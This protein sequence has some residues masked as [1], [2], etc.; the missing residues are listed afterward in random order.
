MVATRTASG[1]VIPA[2]IS[3]FVMASRS[4]SGKTAS[5]IGAAARALLAPWSFTHDSPGISASGALLLA[6]FL[7]LAAAALS[8]ILSTW[9]YLVGKGLLMTVREMDMGTDDLP[10]DT[11]RQVAGS[12]VGSIG[13]W[14]GLL[15]LTVGIAVGVADALYRADR[16]GFR[17][18]VR[19]TCASTIW[20]VVWA[21][22]AVVANSVQQGEIRHP[23]AAVRAYAQLNQH[24]FRGSSALAPGPIER[25]PLVARGL[26]RPLA[27]VFPVIWSLALPPPNGRRRVSR[28]VLIG[29]AVVLSWIAW[30]GAW[31]LLPWTAL[32]TWAG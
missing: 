26:L 10:T 20:F 22:A 1:F 7:V 9:T 3:S 30:W 29:L 28:P 11:L 27:V 32:E 21:A 24:W 31:R 25:E 17:V 15:A 5:P 23:A 18:A 13:V 8:T 12:F 14:V 6:I 2:D 19:R 4:S 16:S